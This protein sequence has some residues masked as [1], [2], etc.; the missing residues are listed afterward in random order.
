MIISNVVQHH[1]QKSYF[2]AN[3]S[4]TTFTAKQAQFMRPTPL[5]VVLPLSALSKIG[6][7]VVA[8]GQQ[9]ANNV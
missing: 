4:L 5:N 7:K 9:R 2:A 3:N 6:H 8:G 1:I